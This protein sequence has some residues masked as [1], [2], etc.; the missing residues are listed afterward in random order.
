MIEDSQAWTQV[1]TSSLNI[2]S[3]LQ[4]WTSQIKQGFYRQFL[5]AYLQC[6]YIWHPQSNLIKLKMVDFWGGAIYIYI[7][8]YNCIILY[9]YFLR[10]TVYSRSEVERILRQVW[11]GGMERGY[12]TGVW[13]RG[14]ERGYGTGVVPDLAPDLTIWLASNIIIQGKITIHNH[15]QPSASTAT[16]YDKIC[17]SPGQAFASIALP[18][19]H[20]PRGTCCWILCQECRQQTLANTRMMQTTFKANKINKTLAVAG[21]KYINLSLSICSNLSR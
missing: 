13:N 7:C 2:K 3:E 12:G 8:I 11:N 18:Q 20:P 14:M 10:I 19:L 17:T 6:I 21:S 4:V 1:W 5:K 9:I 15:A 16:C